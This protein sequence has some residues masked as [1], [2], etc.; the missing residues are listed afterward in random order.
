MNPVSEDDA[1][2]L[3]PDFFNA[4]LIIDYLNRQ[5]EANHATARLKRIN[6]EH[7]PDY[8]QNSMCHVCDMQSAR[9]PNTCDDP[10]LSYA[11]ESYTCQQKGISNSAFTLRFGKPTL[12]FICD[13][14]A[15]LEL[16]VQEVVS[17]GP[18]GP[19]QHLR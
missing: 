8:R 5:L 11:W 9:Q 7:F 10:G 1:I 19:V 17:S 4:R 16:T 15:L 6:Q 13:H 14:D 3:Y 12:R 2:T 18:G